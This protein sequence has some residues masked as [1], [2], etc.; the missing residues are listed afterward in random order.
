MT[1]LQD[2]PQD[3]P[4]EAGST[5]PSIRPPFTAPDV[6]GLDADDVVVGPQFM[7]GTVRVDDAA[8]SSHR[9]TELAELALTAAGSSP[10]A[11]PCF[12]TV[13]I[14]FGDDAMMAD[15]NQRFRGRDGPT[16]VLAFPS[17][18]ACCPDGSCSLGGVVLGYGICLKEAADRG[19]PFADHATHLL[20]HGLLHLLGF[21]H[22]E[23]EPR[24]VMES[25][26][27]AIL[28]DLGIANPYEGP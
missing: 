25:I 27:I 8:W 1:A 12:A 20:V 16:N 24:K 22:E 9:P 23:P 11:K 17:S 15:L 21:D 28:A 6:T 26:E 19:I 2:P 14:V 4:E 13:D 10:Y 5:E 18:D 7:R 3:T